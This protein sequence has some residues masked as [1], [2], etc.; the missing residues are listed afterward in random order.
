M[1]Y[2]MPLYLDPH[3][4][5]RHSQR[6]K[7]I[8][9]DNQWIDIPEHTLCAFRRISNHLY[10]W[11]FNVHFVQRQPNNIIHLPHC[12]SRTL[13]HLCSTFISLHIQK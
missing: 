10:R 6:F 9:L 13:D 11:I 3:V 2:F 12:S 7:S 1:L 8:K 4:D 5:E